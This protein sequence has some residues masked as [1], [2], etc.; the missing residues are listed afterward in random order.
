MPTTTPTI[1]IHLDSADLPA[2]LEADVRA[3]LSSSPKDIPP[4]W[5]YDARGSALFDEITRL[6]EYYPTETERSILS[7]RAD[8]IIAT[9]GAR[10]L[11][12]LGSGSSDKTTTLLGAMD[13]AGTLDTYVPFD[14]SASPLRAAAETLLDLH[15]ELRIHGVVGDFDHHLAEIPDGGQRLVAFLGGTVGNYRPGPRARL[16][17]E[18][19]Q[20]L[21]P[22]DHL[23]I[24]IDLVKDPARL[25][26]A[27]DD[28][29][30][31]TAE[32]NLNLL[33][34][35][36]RE[37]DGDF[38]S[39]AFDHVAVWDDEE[40]WIEMRLR[41][42]RGQKVTLAAIDLTVG[43]DEGEEMRTEVSAKF[44]RGSFTAELGAAGL[45]VSSWYTDRA[46]DFALVLAERT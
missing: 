46:A 20:L 37:L 11:V 28:A 18:L 29:A 6:P 27:Y 45:A 31:V 22:D 1:D 15:P 43:F 42:T 4:K 41:S 44:R 3:G 19:A 14:V 34:V 2:Q 35:L 13:R 23:L 17:A 40:E 33:E 32:F 24:G 26:A 8:E 10:T 12:E 39:S 7:E 30:G 5:F 36:N 38:D 21:G 25:V 9:T 16:L